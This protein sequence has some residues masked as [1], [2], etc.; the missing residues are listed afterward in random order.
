MQVLDHE[1]QNWFL[2]EADGELYLDAN[3]NHGA[4]GYS[5]MIRLTTAEVQRYRDDGR[6]YLSWLA[7]DIHNSAPI[8]SDSSSPYQTRKASQDEE[9]QASAALA[10]WQAER[11]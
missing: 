11:D 1:P 4:F 6:G 2:F 8:L 10:A 3:C 7:D 5:F 9:S